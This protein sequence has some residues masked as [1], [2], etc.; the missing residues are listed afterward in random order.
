MRSGKNKAAR[1]CLLSHIHRHCPTQCARARF[2][3][4]GCAAALNASPG[5]VIVGERNVWRGQ[6]MQ[7]GV[8]CEKRRAD[9]GGALHVTYLRARRPRRVCAPLCRVEEE[10]VAGGGAP[11][12]HVVGDSDGK[13]EAFGVLL[14]PPPA[15]PARLRARRCS[16]LV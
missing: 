11:R 16:P 1:G 15:P 13:G 4:A 5:E 9:A 3:G 2:K 10:L 12:E 14:P 7:R 8:E 6:A